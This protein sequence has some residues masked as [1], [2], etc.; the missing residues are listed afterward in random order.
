MTAKAGTGMTIDVDEVHLREPGMEPFEVMISESQERMMAVVEPEQRR[1][2]ARGL[3]EVGTR[4]ERDRRGHHD[5]ASR[6]RRRTGEQVA[7]VPVTRS[8]RRG[9]GLRASR[10]SDRRGSTS[11]RA[12]GP[13][14]GAPADLE[15]AFM[16]LLR[17]PT[18][19]SK[20]WV[21]EQYDHMIFLGTVIGPGGDAAVIRLP[22]AARSR[23]L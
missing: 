23:S 3:H 8:R 6:G 13:G 4:G 9:P 15:E 16:Q 18:V 19:A 7:D 20:R 22:G 12:R 1:A 11:C 5:R 21:W 2:G 17:S 10:S 14:D